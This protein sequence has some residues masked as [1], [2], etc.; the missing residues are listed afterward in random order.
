MLTA[1]MQGL[2]R[3]TLTL[4]DNVT[5]KASPLSPYLASGFAI[6]ILSRVAQ[7]QEGIRYVPP[8]MRALTT[9]SL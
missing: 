6:S 7:P 4:V 9:N 8:G 1:M 2:Q 3:H 5:E